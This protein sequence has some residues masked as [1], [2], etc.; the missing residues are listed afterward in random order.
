MQLAFDAVA[1]DTLLPPE[2]DAKDAGKKK[3]KAK[4]KNRKERKGFQW[5]PGC[6][7]SK[8]AD[9]FSLNQRFDMEC[10]RLLDRIY[11]QCKAQGELD[12]F[13]QQRAQDNLVKK[14]LDH[15]RSLQAKTGE[16]QKTSKFM[17]AIYKEVVTTEQG[18]EFIGRGSMMWE[19]QAV[20][21]WMTMA[22][23]G[24]SKTEADAR[25]QDWF[26]NY[27]ERKIIHD[28]NSPNASKPL[29]LRIP[30]GD[31][32][33]FVNSSKKSKVAE[34]HG[35]QVKKPKAED[36]DK[37]VGQCYVGF[38][39]IGS[40]AANAEM[41]EVAQNMVSAGAG[42]AFDSVS[43]RLADV[44][45]LGGKK[46]DEE[47]ESDDDDELFDGAAGGLEGSPNGKRKADDAD[48]S[49]PAKKSKWLDLG[50]TI[51]SAKRSLR[52]TY[53]S[54]ESKYKDIMAKAK[55]ALQGVNALPPLEQK[56][57]TGEVKILETRLEGCQ[58]VAGTSPP[59]L[60]SYILKF[61]SAK[62]DE[63]KPNGSVADPAAVPPAEV[64]APAA[65]A[66][67]QP[68][69]A[70]TSSTILALQKLGQMAPCN[71][72]RDLLILST[73][74]E[75]IDKVDA[76]TTKEEITDITNEFNTKKVSILDLHKTTGDAI[77][78][79]AKARKTEDTP[80][81]PSA[82]AAAI[83]PAV[84]AV[85]T[86]LFDEGVA[87]A[88]QMAIFTEA[89]AE[90]IAALIDEFS[91]P[92]NIRLKADLQKV[93]TEL[94]DVLSFYKGFRTMVKD[95][96]AQI[97]KNTDGRTSAKANL[98]S[99]AAIR[100]RAKAIVP[101]ALFEPADLKSKS[102]DILKDHL[103]ISFFAL[104][105]GVDSGGIEKEF[106][107]CLRMALHGQRQI[108]M[109]R[110]HEMANYMTSK[111]V[112]FADFSVK[113]VRDYFMGMTSES[114]EQ[115]KKAACL[116][117]LTLEVDTMLYIPAGFIFVERCSSDETVLGVKICVANRSK[118]NITAFDNLKTMKEKN[119]KDTKVIDAFL[120]E[121]KAS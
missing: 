67:D 102:K 78:E 43:M 108:L 34:K 33:D 26:S 62:P 47:G 22:G 3:P 114:L 100:A 8:P 36:M 84:P 92:M 45:S 58:L 50:Q 5:C 93:F 113:Q 109:T 7:Q 70:D 81:K 9:S 23:G 53:T 46:K 94:P 74:D 101:Q 61:S 76:C 83:K 110:F 89:E 97:Y 115:Y 13:N 25:W 71:L 6:D 103:E 95:S 105:P 55:A 121:F 4:A 37:M 11:H 14:V 52:A 44:T 27:K 107:P 96:E 66:A 99:A 60:A 28:F 1:D 49:P 87:H 118:G 91:D 18:T 72:Y 57:F 73:L 24:L 35:Q 59:E 48:Q 32:V 2:P 38:N 86:V 77:G 80:K 98:K 79:L 56:K 117:H 20:E 31:D 65:P 63:E 90:K 69:R 116:Y 39:E 40:G 111:K 29:R 42:S 16:G 75:I 82:K 112:P 21:F 85:R 10:K 106:V 51:N 41:N 54:T 12:W 19:G 104:L 68:D 17:V 15:Y 88:K 64:G 30:T 120:A 119:K